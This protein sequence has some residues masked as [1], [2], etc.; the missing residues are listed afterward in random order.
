MVEIR[1]P[2]PEF[3]V[4]RCRFDPGLGRSLEGSDNL[5]VLLLGKFHGEKAW[6]PHMVHGVKELDTNEQSKQKFYF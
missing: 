3:A 2:R 6:W 4:R 1:L 5:A